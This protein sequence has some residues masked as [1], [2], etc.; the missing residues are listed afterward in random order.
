LKRLNNLNCPS[1]SDFHPHKAYQDEFVR[2]LFTI[3]LV[4]FSYASFFRA[5]KIKKLDLLSIF[6]KTGQYK[7]SQKTNE[8]LRVNS[9]IITNSL[10]DYI[11]ICISFENYFKA[12]LLQNGFLIHE[13]NRQRQPE[14][15]KKQRDVP[16][17]TKLV[18]I[19]KDYKNSD[20]NLKTLNYSLLLEN[21][22]YS[23]YYNVDPFTIEYLK[24][25]N[26]MRNDLHLHMSETLKLSCAEINSLENLKKIV[27]VDFVILYESLSRKMGVHDS[28]NLRI[29]K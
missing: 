4:K 5:F 1:A 3:N 20:V 25:I 13:I 16:I 7:E 24:D 2:D 19:P 22:E 28:S 29:P 26:N 14:L 15:N 8:F 23:K 18:V 27:E 6:V 12:K 17:E 21:K 11:L 9:E 10:I